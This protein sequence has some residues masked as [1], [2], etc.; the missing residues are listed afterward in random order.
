MKKLM[1]LAATVALLTACGN[2]SKQEAL[3]RTYL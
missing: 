1:L 3:C 2:S